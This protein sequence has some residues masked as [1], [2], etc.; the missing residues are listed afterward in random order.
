[1]NHAWILTASGP[2]ATVE[3]CEKCGLVC[4]RTMSGEYFFTRLDPQ[5]AACPSPYRDSVRP[6]QSN[7]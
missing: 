2:T 5:Y 6:V 7:A 1:M 3:T 4:I